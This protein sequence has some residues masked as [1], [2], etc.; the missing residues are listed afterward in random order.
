MRRFRAP[1]AVPTFSR[2]KM[3]SPCRFRHRRRSCCEEGA[4]VSEARQEVDAEAPA[5][6]GWTKGTNRVELE[7][8][9]GGVDAGADACAAQITRTQLKRRVRSG[10]GIPEPPTVRECE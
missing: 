6:R 10:R 3:A 4:T 2:R 5:A 1:R 8:E 9:A 7:D